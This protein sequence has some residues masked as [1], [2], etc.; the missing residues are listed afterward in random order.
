MHISKVSKSFNEEV[1]FL[2]NDDI[3]LNYVEKQ[4][5]KYIIVLLIVSADKITIQSIVQHLPYIKWGLKACINDIIFNT[6]LLIK[7]SIQLYVS[8]SL[9]RKT[10][11]LYFRGYLYCYTKNTPDSKI[12]K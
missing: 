3:A 9:Q 12:I 4:S 10:S 7:T 6:S 1:S 11:H 2:F 8:H 5:K